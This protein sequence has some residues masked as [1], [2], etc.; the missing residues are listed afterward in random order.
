LCAKQKVTGALRLAKHFPFNFI[1]ILRQSN[2]PNIYGK[3]C[4]INLQFG[5][6]YSPKRAKRHHKKPQENLNEINTSGR[7]HQHFTR[8]FFFVKASTFLP[9]SFCQSKT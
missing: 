3:N 7:F 8:A 9:K 5:T 1:N 2:L 6:L 4:Q